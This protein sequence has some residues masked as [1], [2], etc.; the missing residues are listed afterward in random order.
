MTMRS[1]DRKRGRRVIKRSHP[2]ERRHIPTKWK[3]LYTKPIMRTFRIKPDF[4]R[5]EVVEVRVFRNVRAMHAAWLHYENRTETTTEHPLV[6]GRCQSWYSKTTGRTMLRPGLVVARV[7]LN[8]KSLRVRC[9]E[10]MAHEAMHAAMAYARR[11]KID[12]DLMEG[13][14]VMVHAAGRLVF[15]TNNVLYAA[16]VWRGMM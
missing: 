14:E 2:D 12:L 15:Q 5:A 7:Y 8:A 3:Q 13:E 9:V 1:Q 10:I 11:L 4:G 6:E 16:G